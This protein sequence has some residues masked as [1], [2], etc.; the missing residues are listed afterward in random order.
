LVALFFAT[1]SNQTTIHN[2]DNLTTSLPARSH[3]GRM[4]F[5]FH[6]KLHHIAKQSMNTKHAQQP[7]TDKRRK[8]VPASDAFFLKAVDIQ[9]QIIIKKIPVLS[10][11]RGLG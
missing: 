6:L 11:G 1:V 8:E 5:M 9:R 10:K 4:A 2:I 3:V 7:K